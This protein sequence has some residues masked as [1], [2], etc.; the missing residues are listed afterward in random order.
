MKVPWIIHAGTAAQGLPLLGALLT[1]RRLSTVRRWL[2][3]WSA[4]LVASNL[5]ALTL[6]LQNLNN[7]WLNYVATPI[8]HGMVLWAFSYWQLS[9]VASLSFRLLV[10]LLALTWTGIVVALENPR[11]FSL[12]AEPFAGLLVLGGAIYTLVTRALREPGRLGRQDWLWVALG[13]ALYAGSAV[14]LPPTAHVLLARSPGLVVRA[15]EVKA[16][17]VI[18]AFLAIARGVTCPIP[19][20]PSGG[21]SSRGFSRWRSS[22]PASLR[23]W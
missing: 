14:A 5:L 13:L 11:T 22:S 8:A 18:V 9:P 4:F 1:R 16:V 3:T 15:Y 19:A 10:P 12:L 7:H 20:S 17:F 23:P 21:S 6:S 2:L